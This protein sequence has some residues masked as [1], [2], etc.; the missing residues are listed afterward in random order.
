MADGR[1]ITGFSLPKVA[2]YSATGGVVSY[3]GVMPLAR[4]VDVSMDIETSDSQHFYANNILAES[5]GG[6]FTNGTLNLTVDGLKDAAR[7]MIMGLPTESTITVGGES[8]KVLD[9]DDRMKIPYVGVGFVVRVMEEGVTSYVPYALKKVIFDTEGLE[10][11]TQEEEVEFQTQSLTAS[12]TR[13]D[14]ANHGWM[15]IAE[16]QATEALAEAVVLAFLT[17]E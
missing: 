15:R 5:A 14:S 12:I 13:D 2:L 8:V 1:I 7:K 17:G 11:A 9:Y 10:A 16:E 3:S 4:G 6:Q